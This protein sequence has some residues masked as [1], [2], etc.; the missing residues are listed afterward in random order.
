[1][2]SYSEQLKTV[3]RYKVQEGLSERFNCPFCNGYNTLGI[4]NIN[5]ILS[6]HCFKASCTV[7]GVHDVGMSIEGIKHKLNNKDSDVKL[8]RPI[9]FLVDYK[10]HE[11]CIKYL[12]YN[13]SYEAAKRELV[14]IKYTPA[15]NRILFGVS[16]IYGTSYGYS[17]RRLGS[18]GPKWVKYGDTSSLFTCGNGKI[19]VIVEDAPS[20]CAVGIIEDYT[21]ISLLGSNL[22]S[23][24]KIEIINNFDSVLVCLD[25]DAATKSLKLAQQLEGFI[26]SSVRLI[27]DDLKYFKP[28]S[29]KQIL[30]NV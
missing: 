16:P 21:G 2:Y 25:P 5:G 7:H 19:G 20:A 4:T 23:K 28:D 6:W 24:H 12:K 26:S 9:P 27:P 14:D 30:S 11:E 18:Y 3:K 22:T 15:D 17:G 10:N 1:M 29:I 8:G 13:N